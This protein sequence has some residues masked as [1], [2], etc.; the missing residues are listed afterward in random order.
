MNDYF[1]SPSNIAAAT[2][3]RSTDINTLDA[4]IEAAFD[5]LPALAALFTDNASYAVDVGGQNALSFPVPSAITALA[6]GMQFRV[7]LANSLTAAAVATVGM[8]GTYPVRR[9][10]GSVMAGEA[11][12]GQITTLTYQAGVL[13]I[14]TGSPM[15]VAANGL[16][17][18]GGTMTGALNTAKGADV[19]AAAALD[20]QSATGNLLHVTGAAIITSVILAPGASRDVIFDGTPTLTN[21]AALK[22]PGA[23]NIIVMA[24]DRATFYGDTTGNVVVTSYERADGNPLAIQHGLLPIGALMAF[25]SD[26]QSNLHTTATGDTY[27]KTGVI[28]D[29]TAYPLAPA[30]PWASATTGTPTWTVANPACSMTSGNGMIVAGL[31][32]G[33]I[34]YSIDGSDWSAQVSF[35]G[36]GN[37]HVR[38]AN[39]VFIAINNGRIGRSV[40]GR[41]WSSVQT[42]VSFPPVGVDYGAGLWV[43]MVSTSTTYYTSADNGLTWTTRTLPSALTADGTCGSQLI[44]GSMFAAVGNT[45]S[46]SSSDGLSWVARVITGTPIGFAYGGGMYVYTTNSATQANVVFSSPDFINWTARGTTQAIST[47]FGVNYL[48]GKFVIADGTATSF[49]SAN[50]TAWSAQANSVT[51]NSAVFCSALAPD[52]TYAVGGTVSGTFTRL[53]SNGIN[54]FGNSA[55]MSTLLASAAT[56]TPVQLEWCNDHFALLSATGSNSFIDYSWDGKAWWRTYN[57]LS[58]ITGPSICYFVGKHHLFS[59]TAYYTSVDGFVWTVVATNLPT[60]YPASGAVSVANGRMYLLAAAA[61]SYTVDGTNWVNGAL[62]AGTWVGVTHGGSVYVAYGSGAGAI[63]ATSADGQTWVSQGTPFGASATVLRI[64]RAGSAFIAA[65]ST[66]QLY[67]STDGATWTLLTNNAYGA[68]P[69]VFTSMDTDGTTVVCVNASDNTMMLWAG[70]A[71]NPLYRRG[72]TT[73]LSPGSGTRGFRCNTAG[74][75]A[76]KNGTSPYTY[77]QISAVSKVLNDF[78]LKTYDSAGVAR[79][80]FYKRVA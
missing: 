47:K 65:T 20:L 79:S 23:A 27:L 8:L 59:G 26:V 2:R 74:L 15:P 17:I 69:S 57:P 34:V 44:Y 53:H 66:G 14:N 62:P 64:V 45:A 19:A 11:L 58:A 77:G 49:Y 18:S 48:F 51:S 36:S 42:T 38:F 13:Y 12:A 55:G 78:N 6:D 40:D 63:I 56:T 60:N 4:S 76:G 54:W 33:A 28:A 73:T 75:F 25:D 43:A 22:L 29:S 7:K 67:R 24:G 9:L 37:C 41:T 39:G 32:N 50:A 30:G 16:P 21:S 35:G 31:T 80:D 52:G 5:K 61:F 68:A 1:V 10:D 71:S 70:G 46:L 3:A 72:T